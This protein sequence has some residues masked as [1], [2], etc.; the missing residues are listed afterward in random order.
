MKSWDLTE[1]EVEPIDGRSRFHDFNLPIILMHAISDL[2]FQYCSPIQARTLPYTLRGHDIVGKAQTGTGKTAAFLT[3]I[4]TELLNNPVEDDYFAGE[5]RSLII[6]PTRELVMQIAGDARDLCKYTN[7]KVHSLVGGIDYDKQKR[8]LHDSLCDILV[9]TP[10]R[11]LDF[12]SS[13]D[14]Y[15][16][17][18]EILVLDEAD[19]MLDMGFI[20]QVR[21]IVRLTPH[22][23]HRHTMFFSATFTPEVIELARQWTV[24][25]T[26]VEIEPDNIATESV[27]QKVYITSTEEKFELL[28]N[29]IQQNE[30]ESVIVFANRRDQCRGL[31]KKL[32]D[33]GF[34]VGLLS[35]EVPQGKRIK[36]LEDFKSGKL[37]ILVATDV[38]G[39]G[40]HIDGISHVVNYTLP[41]EPEDYVHRIGRTGRAGENGTSISFACE[42]DAFLLEPI[43]K[44]LGSK[45][46]AELPAK[47]LLP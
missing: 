19:R 10:G 3:T 6:A 29:I 26:T 9:A 14:V 36:T 27:T 41:E 16:D 17:R 15:L 32:K 40:I 30:V 45:L 47:D 22:P 42:D 31:Q 7:L 13:N 4:I 12:A 1:F 11:L 39:R 46:L 21:R 5:A 20:P 34:H 8:Y 37:T 33:K 2:G 35:G 44:L 24:D 18:T 38:A 25:P 23:D 43:E 28:K